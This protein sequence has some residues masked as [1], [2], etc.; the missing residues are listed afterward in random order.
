MRH[1]HMELNFGRVRQLARAFL[2]Q[3]QGIAI[4]APLEQNPAQRVVYVRLVRGLFRSLCQVVCL[5]Q[6]SQVFRIE[7]RKVVES[8]REIWRDGE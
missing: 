6:L 5:V 1:P 2:Q 3:R 7:N 8:Q 4:V